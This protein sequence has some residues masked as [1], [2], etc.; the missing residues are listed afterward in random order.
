MSPPTVRLRAQETIS[1]AVRVPVAAPSPS[2][3]PK[4]LEPGGHGRPVVT[5]RKKG[6][7]CF[8]SGVLDVDSRAWCLVQHSNVAYTLPVLRLSGVFLY[9]QL[10]V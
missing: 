1:S 6:S 8:R 10:W 5:A 3:K 9:V 7:Y 4:E 2:D